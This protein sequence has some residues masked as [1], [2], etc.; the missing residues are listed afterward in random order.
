M[1][2][3]RLIKSLSE[4]VAADLNSLDD[5]ALERLLLLVDNLPNS[6]TTTGLLPATSRLLALV[7]IDDSKLRSVMA[8]SAIEFSKATRDRKQALQRVK[9]GEYFGLS[10]AFVGSLD[11][12]ATR[13]ERMA[14]LLHADAAA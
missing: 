14:S 6:L 7:Q 5:P 11:E 10:L 1:G 4:K 3:N 12:L 9:D 2:L 13:R 8:A